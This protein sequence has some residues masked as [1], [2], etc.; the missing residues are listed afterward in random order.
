MLRSRPERRAARQILIVSDATGRTAE[1]VVKAALVQFQGAEVDLH[2]QPHV[3]TADG[4]RAAV[5]MASRLRGLI[6]HTL[7]LPD[8]R[9]LML[10]EG[11][12]RDVP[13]IDLL[14]P[15]LLRLEDLLQLQPLAKPGLFREMDQEYRRR[16]EVVEYAVKHDDGQNPRG[17]P[18]GDII[19]VGVSRTSKTP[20]SMFLAGRGLRVANV[21][22]VS[23][24]PLPEELTRLDPRKVVGLT[25]KA[26]RLL[27]LRRARLKQME[28]PPKFPYADPRLI[29]AELEY[30]QSQFSRWGWPVVD[31]TDKSI[32]EVAAEVLVLTGI[33]QPAVPPAA[34]R[35]IRP[36]A[37]RRTSE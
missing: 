16:F 26:E 13:T 22:V 4:V 37:W 1:M 2:V 25:I 20:L 33:D 14:G 19:L 24:L 9:N 11:R 36:P 18:Q 28:T 32:E 10:T 35:G 17:L 8:L 31:V 3:R 23:K 7:V 29:W 6:V 5:Q 21:P 27:E 12:A 15:L 34:L 30:A